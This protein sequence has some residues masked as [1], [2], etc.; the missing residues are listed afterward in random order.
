[1]RIVFFGT[2]TFS[3]YILEKLIE[4]G[5]DIKAV[6]SKPDKP[7]GRHLHLEMTPIKKYISEYHPE[8]PIFQPL[9]VS[10]PTFAPTLESFDADLFVVVAYGEILKQHVLDM[11]K[12]GCINVH[13]S[14][15][16]KFRGAAPIQRAI[17]EG[18]KVTGVSI[19]HL[20]KKMDAGDVILQKQIEIEP[21]ITFGEL[22][23]KIMDL[24]AKALLEVL[25]E[26]TFRGAVQD[27]S[28]V[29]FAP[30]VELEECEISFHETG[31]QIHDLI[32]GVNPEP[33]A[34]MH[35]TVK[36]EQKRLRVFQAKVSD[37][38]GNAGDLL[39]YGKRWVY[40]CREGSI[41]FLDV[42]LE[43]KKRMKAGDLMRG[44][45][46]EHLC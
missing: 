17:I 23:L 29:T 15:L 20:V 8:I 13:T 6:I 10:D 35:I 46:K 24:G 27:E 21:E 37:L 18:E 32:R 25:T 41:E 31:T 26:G 12:K 2:P 16:P 45:P 4:A 42:Q 44:L 40:A 11:P 5:H 19:M 36:G 1:M 43:G 22:E 9:K 39:E 3:A 33:G 34:W 38:N 28:L 30:K 7:K 14:L